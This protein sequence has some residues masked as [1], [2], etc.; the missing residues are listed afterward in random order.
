MQ[1]VRVHRWYAKCFS[2]GSK[3]TFTGIG[4]T[5]TVT[6]VRHDRHIKYPRSQITNL[7][8]NLLRGKKWKKPQEE[9]QRKIQARS[10][11]VATQILVPQESLA[12][13]HLT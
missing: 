10:W 7:T 8:F 6:W 9:Q 4:T 13:C 5:L 11:Q 2:K 12:S 3:A 1:S